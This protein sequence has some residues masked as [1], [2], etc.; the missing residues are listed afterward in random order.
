M[1]IISPSLVVSR[2]TALTSNLPV[3]LWDSLVTTA[4][5]AADQEDA[6]YP[7]TNLANP[8][9]SSLWKSGST[10]DQYLTVTLDGTVETDSIGVARHNW[11]SG[12]CVV[13]VEGYTVASGTWT[14]VIS[15]TQLGDDTPALFLFDADFYTGVR[16]KLQPGSVEPQAAV[17]YCGASLTLPRSVPIGHKPLKYSRNRQMLNGDA[18][19]G[20]FTGNVILSQN[21]GTTFDVKLLDPADYWPDIQPFID[22]CRDPF[23]IAWRP[24]SFPLEVSYA[25]ATNDPQPT[26]SQITGEVDISMQLAGL[27][28]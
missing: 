18:M 13:S 16:F 19:N 7:A 22:A 17:I 20:D 14:E 4:T 8:Q 1:I 26:I 10:A 15:E 12:L 5:I 27:A 21:L 28:L 25:W 3:I 23:F 24:D 6:D 2:R 9:T 11:G